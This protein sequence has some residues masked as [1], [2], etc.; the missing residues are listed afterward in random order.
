M[1][2]DVVAVPR[3]HA[4]LDGGVAV[5]GRDLGDVD[6]GEQERRPQIQ[7]VSQGRGFH[8]GAGGEGVPSLPY[9]SV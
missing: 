1:G 9:G 8:A 2:A 7:A 5:V 6:T 3:P 4:Q